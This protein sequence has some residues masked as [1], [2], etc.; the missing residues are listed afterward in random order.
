MI[1][2]HPSL[3]PF[4]RSFDTASKSGLLLQYLSAYPRSVCVNILRIN[5][6]PLLR[7]LRPE[8][9]IDVTQSLF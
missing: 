7:I 9:P 3:L 1:H 4:R 5:L 8:V 2:S 6:L